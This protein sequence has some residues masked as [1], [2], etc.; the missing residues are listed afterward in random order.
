MFKSNRVTNGD[1]SADR[2]KEGGDEGGEDR[3]K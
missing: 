1:I 2:K 3:W